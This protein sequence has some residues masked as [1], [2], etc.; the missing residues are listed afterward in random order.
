MQDSRGFLW[1]VTNNGTVRYDGITFKKYEYDPVNPDAITPDWFQS[2]MEDKQGNIWI[3]SGNSGLYQLNPYTDKIIHYRHLTENINSIADDQVTGVCTDASGKIWICTFGGLNSFDKQT[4]KF[5]LYIHEKNNEASIS[6][7]QIWR[8]CVDDQHN[9][10][11]ATSVGFDCFNPHTGKVIQHLANPSMVNMKIKQDIPL[12]VSKGS[13]NRI[14][15]T[16][17]NTGTFEYDYT[18]KKIIRHFSHDKNSPLFICSNEIQ[19]VFED[20][21]GNVWISAGNEID[22]YEK[23]SGKIINA[24]TL[25]DII[26]KNGGYSSMIQDRQG[27][28]WF[29]SGLNGIISIEPAEKR[30]HLLPDSPENKNE[31]PA[32][33]MLSLLDIGNNKFMATT[34]NGVFIFDTKK[35]SV[36]PFKLPYRGR[37]LTTEGFIPGA[38]IDNTGLLFLSTELKLISYDTTTKAI[39]TYEHDVFDN[40][41]IS[42]NNCTGMIRDLKGR[43]WCAVYGG[44]LNRFFP[45]TGKFMAYKVHSGKNSISTNS[46]GGCFIDRKGNLLLGST[47]GGFITFNPDSE[48][49]TCYLHATGKAG[50]VNC[51]NVTAYFETKNGY[52]YFTTQGG[53]LNVFNPET[54]IFRA[55]TTMDGLS[56]NILYSLIEDKHGNLWL[57]STSGI[58]RFVPPENPFSPNCKISIRNYNMSD[59]LPCDAIMFGGV[60]KDPEGKLYFGTACGKVVYFDP[61]ELSDN[62]FIP[63]VYIT[64][65]SLFNNEVLASDSNSFLKTTIE[66]TKE[67]KMSYRENV[68]SFTFAALNFIHPENNRYAHKLEGFD[69]NWIYTNASMRF[70]NYT[71]L[72]PGEYIFNVKGSNND[73]IWNEIPTTIKLIITPPFWKT[74]WFRFIIAFLITL[75]IYSLYRFRLRQILKVQAIRNKISSDLHDDIG[76]TLNSISIFSEVAKH[77]SKEYIRELDM[78]GESSRKVMDAMSDIVWTINPENDSFEKILFRMRSL[79]HQLMKAKKIE[80]TFDADEKLNIQKLPMQMRKNFYLIFKEALNNLVKYSNADRASIF[81]QQKENSIELFIRDNGIGFDSSNP[82]R[83]NGLHN[84]KNR[85][86]EIGAQLDIESESG[87]G[88]SVKLNLKT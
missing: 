87:K 80:Y 17:K 16:C 29:A 82:P 43:Y 85:A 81:L 88:T 37:E 28:L 61:D 77:K 76:S 72:D 39:H 23:S 59:G 27:K 19:N 31:L 41:T 73:G 68:I 86:N 56:S 14:W 50:S 4:G 67:I 44:G 83:G 66:T 6:H 63:P 35:K 21:F 22:V 57:G 51:D 34:E 64:G 11:L 38:Y 13:N 2:I 30:F 24:N 32:Q 10:W 79:T 26:K 48:I 8:M 75:G 36:T 65:F 55:F 49:F 70:A 69:K 12:V 53:G 18:L 5:K 54:K 47:G 9:L 78:I 62:T 40:T 42:E 7:N 20:K 58:S 33:A 15:L 84:M 52:I 71:N 46:I 45:E 25:S 3:A 1:F 60:Y 74:W